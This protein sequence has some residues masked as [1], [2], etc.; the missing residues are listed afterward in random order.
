ML[1][2]LVNMW[3]IWPYFDD[4]SQ[5]SAQMQKSRDTLAKYQAEIARKPEYEKRRL[6]LEGPG[7]QMLS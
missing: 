2:V 4:W 5:L 6:E 3:F 7:S 1:F